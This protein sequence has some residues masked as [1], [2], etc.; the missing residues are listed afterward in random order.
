MTLLIADDA[1]PFT[2]EQPDGT[3]D[4]VLVCDHAGRAIPKRLGSLGITDAEL[5]THI[6]W[7]LG[8]ADTSRALARRLDAFLIT[9]TYSRLVI[10]CNRPPTSPQSI[11]TLS[12]RTSIPGNERL[13]D[14]DRQ[15]RIDAIFRP[16]HARITEELDRRAAAGR[17]AILV[18]MHSFTPVYM[19]QARSLHCG[20]LYLHETRLAHQMLRLLREEPGLNVGENAPYAASVATD[21]A[22]VVHGEQRGLHCVELELRQDLIATPTDHDQWAAR[23]E[24]V[25]AAARDAIVGG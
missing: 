25:F 20:V 6:A 7:D 12:E 11:V 5:A 8:V 14:S 13:S 9:Q 1:S 15:Q 2:V 18:T 10:D 22:L 17:R 16:Y 19:E 3:S 24:R 21:Y 23:L 4:F